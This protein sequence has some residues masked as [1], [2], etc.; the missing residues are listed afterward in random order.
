MDR[1]PRKFYIRETSKWGYA[2]GGHARPAVGPQGL[3]ATLREIPWELLGSLA[4]P[5][6]LWLTAA[7]T[8]GHQNLSLQGWGPGATPDLWWEIR[9]G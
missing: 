7:A 4:G 6:V 5:V 3:G 9:C 2:Q 1:R 8:G